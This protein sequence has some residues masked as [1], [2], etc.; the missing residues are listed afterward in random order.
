MKEKTKLLAVVIFF[1]IF[2]SIFMFTPYKILKN[3][4]MLGFGLR[5]NDHVMIGTI[6]LITS[7]VSV[8]KMIRSKAAKSRKTAANKNNN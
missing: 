2:G 1:G 8:Y 5:H 7:I 6:A 3:T 4:L